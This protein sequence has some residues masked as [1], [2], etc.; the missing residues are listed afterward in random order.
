MIRGDRTPLHAPNCGTK[1]D[2]VL[3]ND[4]ITFSSRLRCLKEIVPLIVPKARVCPSLDHPEQ[5]IFSL[6]RSLGI[7][8]LPGINNA[9][10]AVPPLKSS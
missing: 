3:I 10:S 8:F 1:V 9:R 6:Y 5:I 7:S 4:K 2:L